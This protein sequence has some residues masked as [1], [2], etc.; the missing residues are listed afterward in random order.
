M[1]QPL[2]PN[3]NDDAHLRS[4]IVPLLAVLFG[5]AG[6]IAIVL[7]DLFVVRGGRPEIEVMD[8][9]FEVQPPPGIGRLGFICFCGI[10]AA[11]LAFWLWRDPQRPRTAGLVAGILA[12]GIG[13]WIEF[14]IA[15]LPLAAAGTAIF[16]AP[17]GLLPF[18]A[19][20]AYAYGAF[21]AARRA[22]WASLAWIACGALLGAAPFLAR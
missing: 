16:L 22:G 4:A 15:A 20:G 7:F 17:L 10:D 3:T 19:A 12:S 8:R 21:H 1:T 18:G 6:P 14:G 9:R 13:A 11:T 5:I 2:I